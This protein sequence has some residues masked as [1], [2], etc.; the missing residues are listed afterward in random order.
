M[1][2]DIFTWETPCTVVETKVDI[3]VQVE[4]EDYLD[5]DD[6]LQ[7]LRSRQTFPR[8]TNFQFSRSGHTIPLL[9][10]HEGLNYGRDLEGHP[11]DSRP[12]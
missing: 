10:E 12:L 3:K 1:Y 6:F 2:I 5:D 7:K 4:T 9:M 8:W 11:R